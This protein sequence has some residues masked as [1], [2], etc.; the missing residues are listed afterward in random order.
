MAGIS[1]ETLG[2]LAAKA[3][4]LATWQHA[5][6]S[7]HH[8]TP[9]TL[10]AALCTLRLPCE[11]EQD[12]RESQNRLNAHQQRSFLTLDVG[13]RLPAAGRLVLESGEAHDVV[14]GTAI[15]APGYHRLETANGVVRLAVAPA[16]APNV[17]ALTGCA[18][19]WGPAVQIYS[20]RGAREAAF[21]DVAALTRFAKSA[22]RTGAHLVAINPVH[23]LFVADPSRCSPYAPS[24]RET[25]NPLY[26]SSDRDG[27]ADSGDLI[28]WPSAAAARIDALQADYRAFSGDPDF[29]RFAQDAV[30]ADHALFDALS[31]HF[32]RRG[33][34]A[35]WSG[36]PAAFQQ[37]GTD[38]V[39]RFAEEHRDAVRFQAYLQWRASEGLRGAQAAAE[40]AGM[41][42]G[43]VADLAVGLHPYGSHSWSRRAE[44][45]D[46]L[47]LGAPPDIFQAD[48]QGWGITGFSPTALAETGFEPFLRTVRKALGFAGGVRVDHALGLERLWLIPQGAE[49]RDGVYLKQ[50]FDDLVRLLVLEAHRHRALVIAED[51]GTVPDGFRD[52]M[53]A[54]HLLG[55]R[56]TTFERDA[57]GNFVDPAEWTPAAVAMTSTHDLIPIAGWWAGTDIGW[58]QRLGRTGESE[59]DRSAD[60]A[61]FWPEP[62]RPAPDE[63][64]PVVD[65]AIAQVARAA[66]ELAIVPVEDLIGQTEAPNM[67]GTIDEH[68]NWRRRLPQ[69]DIFSGAA[70]ARR[71]D[72][73]SKE[74]HR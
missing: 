72:L 66:C 46:G 28:D 67:P 12:S 27:E 31:M 54:R 32:T 55:M 48:G 41:A 49:P 25:L 20:L 19:A 50:P 42:I 74:R 56:L 29:D 24:T 2:A 34:T 70:A 43:L 45:L 73:L 59:A 7:M 58:R 61:C 39:R 16:A 1:D 4:L 68:P 44:L 38:D 8:V 15:D 40:A 52:K 60:R 63:P 5:D 69:A 10:R 71:A 13:D 21:G 11:T 30:V 57:E 26:A 6:G 35:D 62:D 53:Q 33:L 47:T 23:A 14:P 37:S 17:H 9:E 51:L 65:K 36:W 3:G 22:A 18:K 64:A